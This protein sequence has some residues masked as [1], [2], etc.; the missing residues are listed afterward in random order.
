[1]GR[2][3][4]NRKP[5]GPVIRDDAVVKWLNERRRRRGEQQLKPLLA[6]WPEAEQG[7]LRT[8]ERTRELYL[9]YVGSPWT[10]QMRRLLA[11][12]TA[13]WAAA[14]ELD[15]HV[16]RPRLQDGALPPYPGPFG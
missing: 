6:Q 15:L 12:D 4:A 10:R 2:D 5:P 1:V 13:A 11:Q 14:D 7:W 9:R 8:S 16:R 3:A